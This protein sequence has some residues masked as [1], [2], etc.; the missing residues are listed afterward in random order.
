MDK[1]TIYQFLV[2]NKLGVISTT[3]NKHHSESALVGIAITRKYA[4]LLQNP[5]VAMVIGWDNETT[6]QYE[7]KAQ[8]LGNDAESENL[9]EI[10]Y[11][12][13][14]DGRERAETCSDLVHIKI[15]PK[16]LRFSNFNHPVVIEE[17]AF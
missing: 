17:I 1:K 14:P 6:I 10:Y 9:K 11:N 15:T 12:V 8:V 7:G 2:Q 16:W 4:N 5:N 13:Y 3:N